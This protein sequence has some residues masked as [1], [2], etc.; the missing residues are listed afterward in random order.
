M[1]LIVLYRT[2]SVKMQ[3]KER[4]VLRPSP[5]YR[6]AKRNS[7]KLLDKVVGMN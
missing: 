3:N 7:T 1:V 6:V 4:T 5:I 2:Y